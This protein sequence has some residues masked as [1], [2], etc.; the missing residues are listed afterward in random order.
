MKAYDTTNLF[1]LWYFFFIYA[2]EVVLAMIRNLYLNKYYVIISVLIVV[3]SSGLFDWMRT[4]N[5]MKENGNKE[6]KQ[7]KK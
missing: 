4:E 2:E 7:K 1:I 3:I 5:K 6:N